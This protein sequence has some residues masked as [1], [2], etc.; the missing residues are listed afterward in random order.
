[1]RSLLQTMIDALLSTDADAAVGAEYGRPGPERTAQRDGYRQRP[2]DTR[3]GTIG[4]AIPKLRTGSYFPE[5]LLERRKR[6]ETAY[7][8]DL[9]PFSPAAGQARDQ[10]QLEGSA[11]VAVDIADPGE[12]LIR[13]RIN[14]AERCAIRVEIRRLARAAEDVV[15]QRFREECDVITNGPRDRERLPPT[16]ICSM[17][18]W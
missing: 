3:A 7:A 2:L 13:V 8:F 6:A 11:H 4:V 10:S 14:V 15:R 18:P 1:M 16:V 12:E 17:S 9:Q 5:W